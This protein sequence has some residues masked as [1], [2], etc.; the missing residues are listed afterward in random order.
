MMI[1]REYVRLALERSE[2]LGTLALDWYRALSKPGKLAVWLWA[3]LHLVLGALFWLIGPE[4]I[5]AWFARLAD[6]VRET[7]NGWW[8]LSL[9]IVV[10]SIPPLV[11]YGTAQT[12]VGFAYGVLPG[13]WISAASCLVGGAVAFLVVRRLIGLFAPYI[14]RDKTFAALSRAVRVKGALASSSFSNPSAHN[15]PADPPG[16][17]GLPL[18]VLL[19]LCPFPYPYSNAFFASIETV[20]LQEFMLA[21]LS[22]S[23]RRLVSPSGHGRSQQTSLNWQSHHTKAAA[24]R[25]SPSRPL[26]RSWSQGQSA[27]NGLALL[28]HVFIG[29]RTYL[30]ADP[31]SRHKMDSTTRWIK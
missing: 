18:I 21:T 9:V 16:T 1:A 23:V 5:F 27:E 7:P 24:V 20:S 30:F 4:R 31:T 17:A 13:F 8:I 26:F 10:T 25:F 3:S 12:L 22:V 11:G 28:R 19:R 29:H 2:H 14:Q 15:L 6:D